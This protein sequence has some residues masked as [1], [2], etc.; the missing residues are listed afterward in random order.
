MC[1]PLRHHPPAGVPPVPFER[2]GYHGAVATWRRWNGAYVAAAVTLFI[3]L[4]SR[5]FCMP[6]RRRD[7]RHPRLIFRATRKAEPIIRRSPRSRCRRCT[8]ARS[9]P[10]TCD[11]EQTSPRV[12]SPV[13]PVS[14]FLSSI[15]AGSARDPHRHVDREG[16]APPIE[17]ARLASVGQLTFWRSSSTSCFALETGDPQ[18]A[19]GASPE[20]SAWLR[21]RSLGGVLQRSVGAV[22]SAAGRRPLRRVAPRRDRRRINRMNVVL[23]AMTFRRMPWEH[24][25]YPSIASGRSTGLIAATISWPGSPLDAG[26]LRAGR[27]GDIGP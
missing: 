21:S 3:Y 7:L 4:M 11:A 16:V 19:S 22:A 27:R 23:F 13:M 1:R 17:I 14:F 5:T 18:P 15:A 8:R 24:R 20:G 12:W 9:A 26:A 6:Q 2:W 10:N 25:S